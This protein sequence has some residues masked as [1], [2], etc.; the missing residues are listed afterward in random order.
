MARTS[1]ALLVD[2]DLKGLESLVYGFQGVDWRSTACATPEAAAFLVRASGADII[3]VVAREPHDKTLTLLRQLLSNEETRALPLLVMGPA[4]LRPEVLAC[5]PID[6]LPT[7]VFVRDVIAASRILVSL[8]N[9]ETHEPGSEARVEGTTADFGLFSII[10]VMTGL[11]R[12]GVLQVE[13]ANRRGEILFSEGEIAGAQVGSLQGQPAIHH[14]LLWEDAKIELRLRA[15]VRRAQ[16]N[17]RLDQIM[18]EAER[19]VRDYTYAIQGIGPASSVYERNDDKLAGATVPPEVTPVLRLCDG[20]RTLTDIIDESPFRIFDTVRILTRL[21]DLGVLKRQKPQA[22]ASASIPPLQKFWETARIASPEDD[23]APALGPRPTP[24]RIAQ[25]DARIGEPNRRRGQRRESAETPV[26]G[27]PL[28]GMEPAT[29][30]LSGAPDTASLAVPVAQ[31]T[32]TSEARVSGTIDL[33]EVGDQRRTQPDRRNRPSVTIDLAL[34]QAAES[35]PSPAV[36]VETTTVPAES[37]E[38]TGRATGSLHVGPASGHHRRSSAVT[39]IAGGGISI[40]I[41]P[42]LPSET[43]SIAKRESPTVPVR[44]S[45]KPAASFGPAKAGPTRI[46]ATPAPVVPATASQD[47]AVAAVVVP[48]PASPASGATPAGSGTVAPAATQGDGARVAG[49]LSVTASQRSTAARTPSKGASVEL[50]PVLMA[51]LGRLEKATTPVGPPESDEPLRAGSDSVATPARPDAGGAALP[52]EAPSSSPPKSGY[53]GRATGTL[54]VSPSS[55][56]SA[57]A[58]K[59]PSGGVS[60]ALDPAL[61]AEAQRLDAPKP[62]SAAITAHGP[63]GAPGPRSG[64]QGATAG[65]GQ[66]RGTSSERTASAA[67]RPAPHSSDDSDRGASQPGKHPGRISGAFNAIERD[68]FAREADLYKSETEDNFA[69]LDDPGSKGDGKISSG[70]RPSKRQA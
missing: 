67:A 68:F 64:S 53:A 5:G 52:A 49:T 4:S 36:S 47:V 9:R 32:G 58:L 24:A 54:S 35:P 44:R 34:V 66:A 56:S 19:F 60:V 62:Q 26:L 8:G 41:D 48:A 7:P 13:G 70:R 43:A 31:A 15:V 46:G 42:A 63:A 28:I 10:R 30:P 29:A 33:R 20:Q 40:E 17:R 25:V 23:V 1:A 3:V 11:L 38:R 59:T 18:D 22:G 45:V 65:K 2:S 55:R 14:L 61:V 21:V 6:F 27:T 16:F 69:D 50:D 37:P 51:E 39:P 57:K 12:S